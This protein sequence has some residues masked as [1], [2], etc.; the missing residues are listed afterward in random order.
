MAKKYKGFVVS[1]THWD[2]AWYLPFEGFRYRLVGTFDKLLR[3]MEEKPNYKFVFDG[4]T[5]VVEDYLQ[6]RPYREK[7]IKKF[8]EKKQLYLG[9]WYILPDEYLISAESHVRNLLVGHRI[10]GHYGHVMKAGYMPD[11]FGHISQM[12]QI[13]RGFD[14][15]SFLFMRGMGDEG[16]EL[17]V[18][19]KWVA[20]DGE[21]WVYAIHLPGGYG[22][23][24]GCTQFICQVD[25]VALLD[26]E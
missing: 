21:S 12:P 15:D 1:E 8:V 9:P 19:F 18:E 3:I 24:A 4:Q 14:L 2:R 17:G 5:V 22:S 6:I 13:L 10:A 20:S 26:G 23:Q 25:T 7:E 16:E 11:P